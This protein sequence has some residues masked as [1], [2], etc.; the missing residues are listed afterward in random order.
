MDQAG[1]WTLI[2]QLKETDDPGDQHQRLA[3]ILLKRYGIVFRKITDK[4]TAAPAWRVLVKV[5]RR[6][7]SRGEIRGGRFVEGVW[8]EQFALPEAI[9]K[10]REVRKDQS[11]ERL[12]AISAADPLNLVGVITPGK[13]IASYLNNRI[14]FRNGEPIAVKEGKE[15]HF[16]KKMDKKEKW[17]IQEALIQRNIPPRLRAYLGRG[18]S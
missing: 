12:A 1:R 2:R 14:L 16:L 13:R 17:K 5:L 10:L 18:I 8:G 3:W 6:M 11:S 15:L 4:E 9:A 7:E